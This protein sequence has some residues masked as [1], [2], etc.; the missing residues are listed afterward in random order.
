MRFTGAKQMNLGMDP[1]EFVYSPMPLP[2]SLYWQFRL[3]KARFDWTWLP[4]P[5]NGGGRRSPPGILPKET[6]R[7]GRPGGQL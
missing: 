3:D 1:L 6:D 2:P 4:F 7:L 5:P